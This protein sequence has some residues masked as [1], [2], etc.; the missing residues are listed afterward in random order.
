M[1]SPIFDDC[2]HLI[3]QIPQVR[4]KHIYQ[5]ANKCA[6]HLAKSGH[7]QVLDFII[8]SAPPMELISFVEADCHGV[9]CN[10]LCP[11]FFALVE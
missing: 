8:H 9:S 5:E 2:K 4:L 1:I 3:S 6:D 11:E 7:S 10:R